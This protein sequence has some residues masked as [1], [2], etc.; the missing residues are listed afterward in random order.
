MTFFSD[1]AMHKLLSI[2]IRVFG[3]YNVIDYM[4]KRDFGQRKQIC[5]WPLGH[6]L[7]QSLIFYFSQVHI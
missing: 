4:N 6:G 3:Y 7:D 2:K 5:Q 1:I